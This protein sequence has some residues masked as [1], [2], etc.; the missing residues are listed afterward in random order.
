MLDKIILIK[1]T[2]SNTNPFISSFL[3]FVSVSGRLDKSMIT[4]L[5]DGA[6]G[7]RKYHLVNLKGV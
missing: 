1:A 5:W 4:S 6:K 2:L 7:K 3:I